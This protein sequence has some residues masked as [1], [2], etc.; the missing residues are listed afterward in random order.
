M[1]YAI[2]VLESLE[3]RNLVTPLLLY[4]E[5]PTRSGRARSRRLAPCPPDMAERWL[6]HVQRHA[7]RSAARGACGRRGGARHHREQPAA[8]LIR[9]FLDSPDPRLVLHGGGGARAQRTQR[10]TSPRVDATLEPPLGDTSENGSAARR[11]VAVA[12]RQIDHP[13]VH[14][15]LIPLLYDSDPKVAEEA[16]RSVRQVGRADFTVRADAVSLLRIARL[17]GVA[18]DVLVSYGEEVV[19]ALALLPPR[20]GRGHLGPPPYPGDPRPAS[21]L[22]QSMDALAAALA[23]ETDG[24]L[25]FKLISAIETLQRER[26]DLTFDRKA[27]EKLALQEARRVLHRISACTTTCS[28][29]DEAAADDSLLSRAR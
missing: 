28:T 24:F 21:P 2:D 23:T 22:R 5:S 8:D 25:R 19:D 26:P 20:S 6:P 17:K 1:L 10:Q 14:H 18:R 12:V 7:E 15:L 27:V 16:I 13:Q 4:H 11:D 9:P 3:K 29:R